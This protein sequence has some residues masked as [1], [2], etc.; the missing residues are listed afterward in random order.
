MSEIK[1][2]L[3]RLHNENDTG[4]GRIKAT[5][6]EKLRKDLKKSIEKLKEDKKLKEIAGS[7]GISYQKL[8]EYLN[9]KKSI[10]LEILKRLENISGIGFQEDINFLEYGAGS[11]KRKVK[12]ER[13]LTPELAKIAGAHCADG[14][15]RIRKC[16]WNG[17][18][19]KHYELIIREGS[20]ST[21]NACADWLNKTFNLNIKPKQK[22]N[23]FVIYISNKIILR[24]FNRILDLPLGRKTEKIQV[25][26]LIK[27]SKIEIKKA[28]L[29]G[30]F[31]FDGGVNYRNGY[32]ELML[33]SR[34]FIDEVSQMLSQMNL[35]PDLV[36]LNPD[37]LGRYRLR[38]RK[39]RKLER[40]LILFERE[41]E[42]WWRLKEHIHGLDGDAKN[43]KSLRQKLEKYYP[44]P[45]ESS[46]SFSEVLRII[47]ESDNGITAEKLSELLKRGNTVVYE[48]LKKLENWNILE[49]KYQ[50]SRKIWSLKNR[51]LPAPRR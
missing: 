11:T 32:V 48:Y 49:S 3:F 13:F 35:S 24:Y 29:Q 47:G 51:N 38:I 28:F 22:E 37:K 14:S 23:H 1:L 30:V 43:L 7:L 31:M 34:E 40:A 4:Q 12:A 10:P 6:N 8:W 15:L 33:K 45:R 20:Y 25:P 5:L 2:D 17:S 46:T 27:K 16:S 44:K 26:P 39:N 19:A 50:G 21:I 42:K 41:S 36:K 9:R 18:K